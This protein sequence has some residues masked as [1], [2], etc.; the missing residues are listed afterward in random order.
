M[1]FTHSSSNVAEET[2]IEFHVRTKI[3]LKPNYLYKLWFLDLKFVEIKAHPLLV[4]N[5]CRFY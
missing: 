4:N 1:N 2:G 3:I 5:L